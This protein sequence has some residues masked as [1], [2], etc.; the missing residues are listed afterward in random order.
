MGYTDTTPPQSPVK[1][2]VD[3]PLAQVLAHLQLVQRALVE[4]E[5]QARACAR[6]LNELPERS[7]EYT[8]AAK[9]AAEAHEAV[10]EFTNV[11]HRLLHLNRSVEN[12]SE[13]ATLMSYVWYALGTDAQHAATLVPR[14]AHLPHLHIST[15]ADS[16]AIMSN[17]SQYYTK[18]KGEMV[19]SQRV[20]GVVI[21]TAA[22]GAFRVEAPTTLAHARVVTMT[23]PEA[24][25]SRLQ[26]QLRPNPSLSQLASLL[27][28]KNTLL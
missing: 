4:I 10:E 5:R 6:A 14:H 27:E 9:W 11:Y 13:L 22:T 16:I 25:P 12:P 17:V 8:N 23:P 19:T 24:S 28:L 1:A 21:G 2:F 18:Y 3:V 20:Y 26:N 7:T 15:E